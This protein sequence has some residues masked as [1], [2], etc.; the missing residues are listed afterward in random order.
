[1]CQPNST[2]PL[3]AFVV[4]SSTA[5]HSAFQPAQLLRCCWVN[6]RH[7]GRTGALVHA[8]LLTLQ[9]PQS[10]RPRQKITICSYTKITRTELAK[11]PVLMDQ[12]ASHIHWICVQLHI[13]TKLI[14]SACCRWAGCSRFPFLPPPLSPGCTSSLRWTSI[15]ECTVQ[16]ADLPGQYTIHKHEESLLL[17]NRAD[18][19]HYMAE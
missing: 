18:W 11:P 2:I 14:Q 4:H 16:F 1:M 6:S 15:T 17:G 5:N 3:N 9:Q 13:T 7:F 10:L 19:V 12:R 8:K